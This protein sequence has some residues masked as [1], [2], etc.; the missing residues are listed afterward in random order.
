MVV[1]IG[2]WN[3]FMAWDY[4]DAG[5][6]AGDDIG[7][8]GRYVAAH[9]SIPGIRF[10][11]AADQKR[12]NYYAWGTPSMWNERIRI[13]AVR[14]DEVGGPIAPAA[15]ARFRAA[16]PFAIFM[17]G[18]LWAR[19]KTTLGGRYRGSAVRDVTPDG[20]LVVFEVPARPVA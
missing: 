19:V 16:R 9:R 20:R 10:Y 14:D 18:D 3:G 4:I 12:W 7:G 6:R 13:F 11:V 5:R 15:L 1:P 8:T 2:V 17:R